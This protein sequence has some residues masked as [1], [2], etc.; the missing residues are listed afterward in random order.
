ML[1]LDRSVKSNM[2]GSE[3]TFRQELGKRLRAT[4]LKAGLTQRQLGVRLG[5]KLPSCDAYVSRLEQG[6][7]AN[8]SFS[9]LRRYLLACGEADWPK[10]RSLS[11]DYT[12]CADEYPD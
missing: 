3:P 8:L 9:T 6:R 1:E 5:M 11:A 2:T 7:F 12:D 4:R 10:N